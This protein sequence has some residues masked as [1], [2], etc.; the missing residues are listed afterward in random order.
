MEV[1]E[2]IVMR[3]KLETDIRDQVSAL[4]SEFCEETGV[5]ISGVDVEIMLI[6]YVNGTQSSAVTSASVD[7]SL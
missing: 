5:A 4:V 2:L 3:R 6:R 7:I 1:S